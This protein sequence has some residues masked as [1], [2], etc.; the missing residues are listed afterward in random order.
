ML[1]AR[2]NERFNPGEVVNETEKDQVDFIWFL[3]NVFYKVIL[4]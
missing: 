1:A 4:M 2:K 3:S